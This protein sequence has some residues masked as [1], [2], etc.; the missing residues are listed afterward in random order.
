MEAKKKIIVF[1]TSDQGK[2]AID[3]IH[4]HNKFEIVGFLDQK[5]ADFKDFEG[6]PVLGY[7]EHIPQILQKHPDLH[8]FVV[9][10]GDN[11]FR[12]KVYNEVLAK[13]Q[14]TP[15]IAIHA[16]ATVSETTQIGQ[17][18]MITAGAIVNNHCT[19]GNNVFLGT[20]T[21]VDHD[22]VIEDHSSLLPGVTTGGRVIIGEMCAI[23]LGTNI[24][25]G[26][27]IG[28]NTVIGAGST[29]IKDLPEGIV[30]YGSPAKEVRKR[31]KNDKYL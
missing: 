30:A 29:V 12:A 22:C 1:G 9:A 10:I 28:K 13:C 25:H 23:G 7:L 18:T 21:S 6:Y 11:F 8:G 4:S 20:K 16:S 2:H 27:K 19:I 5:H 14:L 31:E 3:I 15:I 24:I 26:R 17:G